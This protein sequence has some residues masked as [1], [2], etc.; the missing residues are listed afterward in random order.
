MVECCLP[1][2]KTPP[3]QVD[4]VKNR[5]LQQQQ[6]DMGE[7]SEHQLP[8]AEVRQVSISK[9]TKNGKQRKTSKTKQN[10]NF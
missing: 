6:L 10:D 8:A 4:P 1:L 2:K 5:A 9:Q 7:K 3:V